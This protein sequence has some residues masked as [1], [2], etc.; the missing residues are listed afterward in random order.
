MTQNGNGKHTLR[1]ATLD[2]DLEAVQRRQRAIG[3]RLRGLFDDIVAEGVP[4]EFDEL[5]ERLEESEERKLQ[6]V[7]RGAGEV[8][9]RSEAR[10]RDAH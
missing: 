2:E 10:G 9:I 3:R 4:D 8:R 1:S 5:L 7:G 6:P